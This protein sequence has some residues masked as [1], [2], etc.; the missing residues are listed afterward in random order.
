MPVRASIEGC[1]GIR[2]M[3][4][5]PEEDRLYI[6]RREFQEKVDEQR[7]KDEEAAH[8]AAEERL[9]KVAKEAEQAQSLYDRGLITK[10]EWE[11]RGLNP[12]SYYDRLLMDHAA[13]DESVT[14]ADLLD[15]VQTEDS[16][17]KKSL[18]RRFTKHVHHRWI[19]YNFKAET[20]VLKTRTKLG[21]KR[22]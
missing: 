8:K 16:R 20:K 22:T 6:Y 3:R 2:T 9:K 18:F 19:E 10:R 1:M 5:L 17:P 12:D 15:D 11:R 21:Y 14:D 4:N 13:K 7:R